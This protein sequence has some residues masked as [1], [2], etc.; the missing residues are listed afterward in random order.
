[1]KFGYNTN[2]FAFHELDQALEIISTL[3][4][5][6]VALTLDTHHLNPFADDLEGRCEALRRRLEDLNLSCVVETGSRFL[7]DPWRK[8]QPTL[9]SENFEGRERRIRF[10]ARSIDIAERLG[11]DVVSLWSGQPDDE[12]GT[13]VLWER[14]VAGLQDVAHYAD[15]HNVRIAFEPEPGM[16]I[17][18]MESYREL[19]DRFDHPRLGLTL[20]LGHVHCLESD[21][22]PD[23]ISEWRDRIWN[24]HIED[25][26]KGVHEHLMFGDGEID[27]PPVLQALEGIHY[28]SGVHVEL[29]RHAHM[30]PQI[31]RESL[32]FLTSLN[33]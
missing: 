12:A 26:R 21:S 32:A 11:S 22:I 33:N 23:V 10:L 3:G 31:A 18:T 2:G 27:F 16:F 20:D 17:D 28:T 5:R 13:A 7:L 19:L 6:S 30:A 9:I 25:M 15:E 8:H 29:S 14:L 1:M 24:V 4:Y